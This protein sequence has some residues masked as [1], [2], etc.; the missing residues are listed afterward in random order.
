MQHGGFDVIIGNPPY[1]EYS[2]VKHEYQATEPESVGTYGN[3]YAAVLQRS[4]TL[5]R[6]DQSYLGLI[7]P[8]SLCGSER[9]ASLRRSI[10][11]QTTEVW[12][13]NFEIF[14]SR[15]FDGAFQRLSILLAHHGNTSQCT[16]YST[17]IQR[18]YR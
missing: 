10:I 17:R 6:P 3:L 13:S 15:L 11:K 7:V 8:L 16:T 2:K 14:P 5:C 4:L 9:F 12:L 1:V 18:W